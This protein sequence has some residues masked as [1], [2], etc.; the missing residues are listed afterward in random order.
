MRARPVRFVQAASAPARLG[1]TSFSNST[2]V[3]AV[4]WRDSVATWRDHLLPAPAG[5]GAAAAGD[6]RDSRTKSLRGNLDAAEVVTTRVN[7]YSPAR[8]SLT[9]QTANLQGRGRCG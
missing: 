8:V 4:S 6:C 2:E 3:T 9:E 7:V 1:G 5:A